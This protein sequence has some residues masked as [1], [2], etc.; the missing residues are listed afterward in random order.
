MKNV[1]DQG[2]VIPHVWDTAKLG[3]AIRRWLIIS[4]QVQRLKP[5]KDFSDKRVFHVLQSRVK[6]ANADLLKDINGLE[7]NIQDM[8][9]DVGNYLD[10]FEKEDDDMSVPVLVASLKEAIEHGVIM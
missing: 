10:D 9:Y 3:M 6:S 5:V 7:D 1:R 4:A 8:V 2:D